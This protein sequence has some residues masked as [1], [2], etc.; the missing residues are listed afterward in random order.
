MYFQSPS[1]LLQV[2]KFLDA[3]VDD[4]QNGLNDAYLSSPWSIQQLTEK[5]A[6]MSQTWEKLLFSSGGALELSKCFYYLIYWEWRDGIPNMVRKVDMPTTNLPICLTSGTDSEKVRIYQ[7]DITESHKTLGV[8]MTPTGSED[9]Q[10]EYLCQTANQLSSLVATSR[11]ARFDAFMAYRACWFPAVG[12]SLSTTTM[13]ERQLQS[14]QS[15]SM[16]IFLPKMG[17]NRHFP[18]AIVYGPPELGGLQLRDLFVEQGISRIMVI[19]SNVYNETELGRMIMIEIQSLQMEAGTHSLLLTDTLTPVPY[20]TKCW[21]S[22]T[23]SFMQKY[24]IQLH[25]AN[26]WNFHLSRHRDAYL[27]DIFRTVDE[28]GQTIAS[29]RWIAY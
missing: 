29:L 17:I 5:L 11:L 8:M 7:R 3:F 16:S 26:N 4:A 2:E 1:A 23:R 27:M 10:T 12:Y 21:I 15:R 22:E 13:S 9:A 24:Q 25:F 6:A 14:V 20:L 19:P 28:D 18:K